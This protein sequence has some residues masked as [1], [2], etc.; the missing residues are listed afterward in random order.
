MRISDF[1]F[2]PCARGLFLVA[3]LVPASVFAQEATPAPQGTQGG[4][5]TGVPAL[6]QLPGYDETQPGD[7]A[8]RQI[9]RVLLTA[10]RRARLSSQMQGRIAAL[11]LE[12]GESFSREDRLVTFDCDQQK[13]DYRSAR[14]KLNQARTN[15][16]SSQS[17]LELEAVSELEVALAESEVDG[18]EAQV[19]SAGSRLKYCEID[20]P[21]DGRVVHVQANEFEV[22]SPGDPLLEIVETGELRLEA[23]VPSTWLRWLEPGH[24]FELRVDELDREFSARVE[25]LGSRVD[26]VSQTVGI[27]GRIVEPVMALRPGMSGDAVF[28]VPE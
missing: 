2:A 3:L 26:P 23:L 5:A 12:M 18:A 17:L 1:F 7:E 28:M 19:E 22:V 27:R 4:G 11:P 13:A 21:Y 25:A 10:P 15:L 24:E 9:V 20:A 6:E 14:A 8:G 16:A